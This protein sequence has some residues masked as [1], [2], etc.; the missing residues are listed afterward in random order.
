[1]LTFF[2]ILTG[3][4]VVWIIHK[5][6]RK[7]AEDKVQQIR[8]EA[9]KQEMQQTKDNDQ[10]RQK[11]IHDIKGNLAVLKNYLDHEDIDSAKAF[12]EEILPGDHAKYVYRWSGYQILDMVISLR[13]EE[14]EKAGIRCDVMCDQ[15][16]E[17]TLQDIEVCSLFENLL[18]NAIEA[19]G[20]EYKEQKWIKLEVRQ[21]KNTLYI[22][23]SNP[24]EQDIVWNRGKIQTH[25]KEAGLHGIGLSIVKRIIEK[26][27]GVIDIS[28]ENQVF[29]VRIMLKAVGTK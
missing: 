21:K 26:H 4:V 5:R 23:I 16:Q 25:K 15:I 29:R 2:S 22:E 20:E 17:L 14:A 11:L 28:T 19:Q 8:F 24:F 27:D 12:L 1:M 10:E 7:K 3:I 9:L 18:T 13:V 6:I